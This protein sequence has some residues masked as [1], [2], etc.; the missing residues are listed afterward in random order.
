M[1]NRRTLV[2]LMAVSVLSLGAASVPAAAPPAEQQLRWVV[3]VSGR[4]PA[5][6]AEIEKH[7]SSVLLGEI[8]GPAQVNR[9]LA[10]VGPLRL[11]TQLERRSR[12]VQALVR[13][14]K[15]RYAATVKT[16]GSGLIIQLAIGAYLPAPGSWHALDARL[17]ALAPQVAFAAEQ[18]TPGGRCRLLHGERA[19]QAQ[20]LGSAF[21]LYVLGALGQAVANHRARWNQEL[22]IHE[23]WK[24]L[25]SGTLQNRPPGQR[26]RCAPT[27]TR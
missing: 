20:P 9:A 13:G 24:S 2:I 3:Q 18:I 25:P 26:Y 6:P 12:V 15:A 23:A 22:R 27:P 1:L 14:R 11:S 17:R 21:K 4:L 16:D 8:G 10:S 19:D 5:S 7:I